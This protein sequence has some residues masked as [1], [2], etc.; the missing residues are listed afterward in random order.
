MTICHLSIAYGSCKSIPTRNE[1]NLLFKKS[2]GTG[3]SVS[4]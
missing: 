3:L 2:G 4:F 1:A